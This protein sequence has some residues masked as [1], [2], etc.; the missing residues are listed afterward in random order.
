[1]KEFVEF[2]AKHLV[3]SPEDVVVEETIAEDKKIS[4]TLKVKREDVGKV[5][6]KKGR[7]AIAIRTLI[8]AVGAKAGKRAVLEIID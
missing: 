3:D 2:I 8:T 6:G 1:M 4:L 5:I 7:T